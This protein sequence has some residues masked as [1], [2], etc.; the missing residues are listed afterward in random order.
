MSYD[1]RLLCK[2]VSL[3]LQRNPNTSLI[4]LS[5]ELHVSGRTIQNAVKAVAGKN[6]R[7]LREELLLARIKNL[8][9]SAP[10]ATTRK[11]SLEVGYKSPRSF[12]RAVRRACGD[13]PRELRSRIATGL[14]S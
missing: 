5:R 2:R 13:S 3:Y 8:L 14:L 4:E 1:H 11:V 6:L 7:G 9:A 10:N 12:A